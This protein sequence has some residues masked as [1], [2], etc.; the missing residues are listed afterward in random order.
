MVLT[1][2]Y[3]PHAPNR[4]DTPCGCPQIMD[5]P[6]RG[7]LRSPAMYR[8]YDL[9]VGSGSLDT[10]AV[11]LFAK[12]RAGACSNVIKLRDVSLLPM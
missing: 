9:F 7:E 10:P 8:T 5:A 4:R 2:P 6:C 1:A 11:E 12:R 3:H